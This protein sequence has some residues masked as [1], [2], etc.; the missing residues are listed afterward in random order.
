M[1]TKINA[2]FQCA[3]KLICTALTIA[4]TVVFC[5]FAYIGLLWAFGYTLEVKLLKYRD[6]QTQEVQEVPTDEKQDA[7]KQDASR[8]ERREEPR[9]NSAPTRSELRVTA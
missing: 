5:L 2:A 3:T 1:S 7:E 6:Q 8:I 4:S 9:S